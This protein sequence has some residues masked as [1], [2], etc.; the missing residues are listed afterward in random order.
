MFASTQSLF[1]SADIRKKPIRE[2]SGFQYWN[3]YPRENQKKNHQQ[4]S[5]SYFVGC[6]YP[7]PPC[8]KNAIAPSLCTP[9]YAEPLRLRLH[10]DKKRATLLFSHPLFLVAETSFFTALRVEGGT[11]SR[12]KALF[13]SQ[14][15]GRPAV[16]GSPASRRKDTDVLVL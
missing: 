10:H 16:A 8:G 2:N 6:G 14:P 12:L 15:S 9:I 4:I 13:E 1:L 11:P 7:A 3:L 5:F